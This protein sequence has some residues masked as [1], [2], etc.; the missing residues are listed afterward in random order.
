MVHRLHHL[1]VP[2][3]VVTA[4]VDATRIVVPGEELA[5]GHAGVVRH[6]AAHG[7]ARL[8]QRRRVGHEARRPRRAVEP[9]AG[10]GLD[11]V[12]DATLGLVR[13][14]H[15]RVLELGQQQVV[16]SLDPR[17]E[18]KSPPVVALAAGD[19][20]LERGAQPGE[21][22]EA[23]TKSRPL[24][25]SA[26]RLDLATARLAARRRAKR[27]RI[28]PE[29]VVQGRQRCPS[30]LVLEQRPPPAC[31]ADEP[32]ELVEVRHQVT[33]AQAHHFL[34]ASAITSLLRSPRRRR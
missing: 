20:R 27:P 5:E 23:G 22:A 4:D 28:G 17:R 34:P 30:G 10:E 21:V 11:D 24:P 9:P 33:G 12:D 26:E 19:G 7:R 14:D 15:V 3:G 25:V 32:P 16:V 6:A 29:A 18:A 31:Q 8:P 13:Q 2:A 1:D